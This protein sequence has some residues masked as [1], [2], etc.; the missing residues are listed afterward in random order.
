MELYEELKTKKKAGMSLNIDELTPEI[1]WKL[2]IEEKKSDYLISQ[3]FDVKESKISYRR[4]KHG[5][6]IRNSILDDFLLAKTEET[7]KINE[8]Y[9]DKLLVD[10][11]LTMISKAITHF[12]FRNGPIEDMHASPNN[13]LSQED[14]KILNKFMVNKIAYVFKLI[15]EN[16][17]IELDFL[18]KHTDMM[19]GHD[20]D[21]AEPDDGDNR[22]IIE[23][24][25][26]RQ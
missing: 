20:W 7:M 21:N 24:M 4:K 1:L 26:K 3:L 25:M 11:N 10:E 16:R 6:T 8:K 23:M 12:A 13:Q 18:I 2:F 19:Y 5:V 15:I 22:K 17:W 14:M 9:R